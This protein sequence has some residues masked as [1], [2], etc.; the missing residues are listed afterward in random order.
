MRIRLLRRCRGRSATCIR[1]APSTM[2]GDIIDATRAPGGGGVEAVG[3]Q[4]ILAEHVVEHHPG[5][6]D[7]VAASTRRWTSSSAPRCRRRRPR[8]R[9]SCPA[10]RRR[11][12]DGRAVPRER[13]LTSTIDSIERAHEAPGSPTPVAVARLLEPT[14]SAA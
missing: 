12:A 3:V 5:A 10:G 4:V 2:D 8:S 13:S 6:R 11:R 1:R 14:R 7:D 9:G